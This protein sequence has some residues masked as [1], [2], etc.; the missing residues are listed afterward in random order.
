M[1]TSLPNVRPV[2]SL[3]IAGVKH[4]TFRCKFFSWN[5]VSSKICC[6]CRL[7]GMRIRSD[8]SC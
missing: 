5:S 1:E 8:P 6:V 4:R 2:I 7:P 3:I